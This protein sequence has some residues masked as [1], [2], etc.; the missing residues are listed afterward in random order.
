MYSLKHAIS[1]NK[2]FGMVYIFALALSFGVMFD[3]F[4]RIYT[5]VMQGLHLLFSNTKSH[6]KFVN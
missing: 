2:K 3:H 5:S 4:C 6:I 1:I